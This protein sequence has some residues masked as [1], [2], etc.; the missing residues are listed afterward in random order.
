MEVLIVDDFL[1]SA[2]IT[3]A[4][5]IAMDSDLTVHTA[6]SAAEALQHLNVDHRESGTSDTDLILMDIDMPEI[7]G[8]EACQIIKGDER[9]KDIPIIMVTSFDDIGYLKDAF[10]AG[11]MDYVTKPINDIELDARV[12]SALSL[13]AESD[14]RKVAYKKLEAESLAKTQILSTVSHE[15][16]TPLTSIMGYIDMLVT[17]R[18]VVGSLTPREEEY[19]QFVSEESH[20]LKAL[21]DDLLDV[22]KLEAGKF[23]L[24][25][26]EIE[27]KPLIEQV[28]FSLQNQADEKRITVKLKVPSTLP[29]ATADR[30]RLSQVVTNLLSNAL[31]Y[32]D[33]GATVTIT[34]RVCDGFLQFNVADTGTG[35]S[36]A[37]QENV[38]SK[39][40]R[41]DN[42]STRIVPGIG[43]G[44]FITKLLV[45]A[46]GGRTSVKSKL[47]KG[48][49]FSFTLPLA[50]PEPIQ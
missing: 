49:T 16:R 37:D 4:S 32:S 36:D 26:T 29:K 13:K 35:I 24:I 11:A 2:I 7:D 33:H 31:N 18:E 19:L 45:E 25:P 9:F 34:G 38:F 50:L 22:T 47:G 3:Q 43:L 12:R 39:F 28:I 10:A 15:L 20:R 40:F 23:K 1:D 14:A 6:E 5:L 30:L 27:V 8:V 46:L 21:I 41:A 17:R 44:L 42:S 48:S